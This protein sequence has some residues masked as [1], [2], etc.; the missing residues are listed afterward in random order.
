MEFLTISKICLDI[1][2]EQQFLCFFTE[3]FVLLRAFAIFPSRTAL[4]LNDSELP[5]VKAA[6]SAKI[7]SLLKCYKRTDV[8]E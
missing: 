1:L 4:N 3:L 2:K 7:S 6:L 5:S 8:S